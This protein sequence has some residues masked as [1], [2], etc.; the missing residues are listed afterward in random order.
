LLILYVLKNN[1]YDYMHYGAKDRS[2]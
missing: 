2:L 1:L